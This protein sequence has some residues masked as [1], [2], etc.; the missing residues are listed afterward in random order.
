MQ[1]KPMIRLMLVDDHSVVRISLAAV[2]ALES[3]FEVVAEAEDGEQAVVRYRKYRPDVTLM[4][5]RM[6]GGGGVE[7]LRAIRA[8]YPDAHI[9]MLTT[10]DLEEVVFAAL[11]AGATGYLL[12]S[13]ERAELVAAIRLAATGKRCIPASLE[14]R[15]AER[16]SHKHLSPRELEVLEL[17]RRGLSNHDI[18]VALGI[19]DHTAKGHVKAILAKMEAAGRAEAVTRGFELG[20]LSVESPSR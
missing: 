2:L 10:Y 6:P 1:T 8:E 3:D 19:S 4:D 18:G 7:S 14:R 16:G 20:I 12:K 13:V 11:E 5:A 9:V 15:L 17:M